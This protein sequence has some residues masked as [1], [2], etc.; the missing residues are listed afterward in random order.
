M[1]LTYFT[2]VSLFFSKISQLLMHLPH[3]GTV[4]AIVTNS[5]TT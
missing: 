2:E 1:E 4:F 5:C 3:L